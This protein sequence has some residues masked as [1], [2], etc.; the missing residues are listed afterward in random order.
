[1]RTVSIEC[2]GC[3]ESAEPAPDLRSVSSGSQDIAV[4][5]HPRNILPGRDKDPR[6]NYPVQETATASDAVHIFE[7]HIFG[8]TGQALQVSRRDDARRV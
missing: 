3:N 6:A 4:V 2:P 7:P 8:T 5:E 1:M